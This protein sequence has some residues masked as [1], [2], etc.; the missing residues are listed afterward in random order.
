MEVL[1]EHGFIDTA[2]RLLESEAPGSFLYQKRRG[3]T[4]LW[5]TWTGSG[6]QDHPMFG[7]CVRQLFTALLSIR[8]TPE[9]DLEIRPQI[10]EKLPWVRG[11]VLLPQGRVGV[12]WQRYDGIIRFEI[13]LPPGIT[14]RFSY[15]GQTLTL[16]N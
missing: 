6:S 4:T 12:A 16:P 5:E 7:A 9:G 11:S 2:L 10:P 3:A 14:A 1:C 8:P 13:N 15:G